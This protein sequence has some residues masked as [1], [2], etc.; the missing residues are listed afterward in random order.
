VASTTLTITSLGT[1]RNKVL[2]LPCDDGH[3]RGGGVV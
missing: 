2:A 3:A 1:W